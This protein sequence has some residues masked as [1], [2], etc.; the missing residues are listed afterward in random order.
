MDDT[1]QYFSRNKKYPADNYAEATALADKLFAPFGTRTA[2]GSRTTADVKVRVRYSNVNGYHVILYKLPPP[3]QE[4]APKV[5]VAEAA[6]EKKQKRHAHD[7]K[8]KSK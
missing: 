8:G 4:A 3:K 6:P 7:R 2:D 1:K 5:V